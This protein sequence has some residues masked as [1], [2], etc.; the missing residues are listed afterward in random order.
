MLNDIK[1]MQTCQNKGVVQVH[2]VFKH[3]DRFWIFAEFMEGGSIA[4]IIEKYKG[5]YSENYCK[6]LLLKAL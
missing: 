4:Q 1:M 5:K 6:Y 3:Q 2:E